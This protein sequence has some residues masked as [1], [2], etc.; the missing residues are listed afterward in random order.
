MALPLAFGARHL[1]FNF[2]HSSANDV[3]V[4]GGGSLEVYTLWFIEVN[5]E[6]SN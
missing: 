4:P 1:C 2:L 3:V 5:P 6:I